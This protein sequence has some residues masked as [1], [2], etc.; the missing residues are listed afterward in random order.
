MQNQP[1]E[2]M[3]VIQGK[4]LP[5]SDSTNPFAAFLS[6]PLSG[7]CGTKCMLVIVRNVFSNT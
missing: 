6:Q 7:T 5:S 3:F 4:I 2:H 1:N